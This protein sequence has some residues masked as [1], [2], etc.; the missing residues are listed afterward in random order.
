MYAIYRNPT[1]GVIAFC[2]ELAT[3][4]EKNILVN[5]GAPLLR[6][7]FNAHIENSSHVSTNTFNNFL[8]S[9][10]L[11]NHINFPTNIA[12]HMLN[13]CIDDNSKIG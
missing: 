2:E 5:R 9:F 3:I 1:L 7:D 13:L 4:V 10:N 11:Q 8:D 6:E 12:Q